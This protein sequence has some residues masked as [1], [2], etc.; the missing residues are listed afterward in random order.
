MKQK[1][2]QTKQAN[3]TDERHEPLNKK[4]A[5][6]I[7]TRKKIMD[8]ATHLFARLGYHK[9]TI[10]DIASH[11]EMTTGAVFHHFGSKQDILDD[12]VE[13]LS[14]H[15][16]SYIDYLEKPHKDYSTMI[17]GLVAIFVARY[18]ADPDAI[19]GLTSLSAE[20]SGIRPP[21][22]VNIQS[23][24]DRFVDAF[25]KAL[26]PFSDYPGGRAAGICFIA[27]LQGSAIQALL[28]GGAIR[29]EELADGLIAMTTG[30]FND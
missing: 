26:K 15:L 16:E 21:V 20:F 3:E 9:T 2:T 13:E 19:I 28:R 18:H 10:Q 7:A 25:E 24:Y 11:I 30:E 27:A 6:R 1:T 8:A 22:I 5:K 12:V 23:A 4:E 14:S 17:R 29:I